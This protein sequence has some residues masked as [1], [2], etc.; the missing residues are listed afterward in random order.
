M[1]IIEHPSSPNNVRYIGL[2]RP[3][4]RCHKVWLN[5][6][7]DLQAHLTVCTGDSKIVWR[8]SSWSDEEWCFA[9]EDPDLNLSLTQNGG[10]VLLGYWT[11]S[12]SQNGRYIK[13]RLQ[14]E[15]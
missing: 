6:S 11:Y 12:F 8:K 15:E 10:R 7:V 1:E 13:R 4:P 9:C 5:C 2:G 14:K 3:C